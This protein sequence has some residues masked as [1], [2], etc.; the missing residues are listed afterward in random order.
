MPTSIGSYEYNTKKVSQYF[1]F[2]FKVSAARITSALR[3]MLNETIRYASRRKQ[4]QK[5]LI[6]FE[7]IQEKLGSAAN[8]LFALESAVYMTAGEWVGNH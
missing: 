8:H 6:E 1:S 4:F 5:R 2:T 7:L 3:I